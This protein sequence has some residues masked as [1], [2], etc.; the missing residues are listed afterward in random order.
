MFYIDTPPA[1]LH[2]TTVM[3]AQAVSPHEETLPDY[4]LKTCDEVLTS[5]AAT[6]ETNTISPS[7]WLISETSRQQNKEILAHEYSALSN[8]ISLTQIQETRHGELIRRFVPNGSISYEYRP[9]PGYIG[10]DQAIFLA[11]LN[12]KHYKI[13]TDIIVSKTLDEDTTLCPEP[14]LIKIRKFTPSP[15]TYNSGHGLTYAATTSDALNGR[16]VHQL[17]ARN[18]ESCTTGRPSGFL[19]L[20]E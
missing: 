18:R 15:Y 9:E 17:I 2:A 6:R 5:G 3:L 1:P 12:G 13:M 20:Q 7:D 8:S 19:S 14:R 11:E 16:A 10:K 4:L